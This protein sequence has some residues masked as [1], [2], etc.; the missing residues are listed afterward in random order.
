MW[1]DE[2]KDYDYKNP[3]FSMSKKL[4]TF[5]VKIGLQNLYLFLIE[6]G[7]FTQVVWKSSTELGCGISVDSN[8]RIVGVCNYNPPGNYMGQFDSNVLPAS[9]SNP[10]IAPNS[11]PKPEPNNIVKPE[12][13]DNSQSI[14]IDPFKDY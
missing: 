10:K 5:L 6:T 13:K 11:N 12:K 1:Y 14:D 8:N 4:L 9:N 2:I 7:H 3:G